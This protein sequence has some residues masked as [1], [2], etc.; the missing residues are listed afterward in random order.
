MN[1]EVTP[2]MLAFDI[3]IHTHI[4]STYICLYAHSCMID[5]DLYLLFHPLVDLKTSKQ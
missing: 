3:D 5:I 1:I 4:I 2:E